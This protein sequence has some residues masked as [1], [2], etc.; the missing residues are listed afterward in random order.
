MN[1][2][3]LGMWSM[4]PWVCHHFE[5]F[6]FRN[7]LAGK[8]KAFLSECTCRLMFLLMIQE[9]CQVF[10][11][12]LKYIHWH[13]NGYFIYDLWKNSLKEFLCTKEIM[14]DSIQTNGPKE[15]RDEY[16]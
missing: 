2:A 12:G 7:T 11:G 3:M 9:S 15:K 14:L 8:V 5:L 4:L 16:F 13:I 6:S 1:L 10:R